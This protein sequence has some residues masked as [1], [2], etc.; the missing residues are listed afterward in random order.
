MPA[1]CQYTCPI[2]DT[3][4]QLS[5]RLPRYAYPVVNI[6]TSCRYTYGPIDRPALAAVVVGRGAADDVAGSTDA[7]IPQGGEGQGMRSRVMAVNLLGLTRSAYSPVRPW[8]ELVVGGTMH[9]HT[10]DNGYFKSQYIELVVTLLILNQ[11][12][13]FWGH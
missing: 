6:P 9:R 4:A 12:L 11:K 7:H 10:G 13:C 2:V 3:P 8:V 5:I 1:S